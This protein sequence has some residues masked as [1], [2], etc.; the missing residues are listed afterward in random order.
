VLSTSKDLDAPLS[1]SKREYIPNAQFVVHG[2]GEEVGTE[3]IQADA[4]DGVSVAK[5]TENFGIWF[6]NVP[7]VDEIVDSS[8]KYLGGLIIITNRSKWILVWQSKC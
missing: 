8:T 7:G 3:G 6:P 4:R 1:R 2:V 5:E